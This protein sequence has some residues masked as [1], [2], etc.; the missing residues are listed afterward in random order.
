MAVS[1]PIVQFLL[2]E[3][4]PEPVAEYRF[5]SPRRW[6]FDYAW[7]EWKLALE[8]EGGTWIEGRHVRPL[9]F[10]KDCIKY[11][12][13]A[14]RGWRVLRFPTKMIE[15]GRFMGQLKRAFEES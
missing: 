10:E 13:A 11:N 12:E 5:A 4:L 8:V 3:R 6:R 15:D 2:A 14:L 9:E 1:N 7:P